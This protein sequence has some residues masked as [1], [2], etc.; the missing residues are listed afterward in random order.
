MKFGHAFQEALAAE[1]YP[2]HWVE[3]AIPYRQLKKLLGKVRE[4]LIKTG[5][6][7]DTIHQLLADHNAEYRL[8]TDAS[9]LL[10]P[11][12]VVRPSPGGTTPELAVEPGREPSPA[13]TAGPCLDL[14]ALSEPTSPALGGDSGCTSPHDCDDDHRAPDDDEWVKIPLNSDGRFFS[15]LQT[16][17]TELDSLQDEERQSM[18]DRIRVLGAEIAEVAKPRK[19][20]VKF[21]K[22]DL[23]RW[24]EIFE[25]YLA[26]QVFFSTNEAAGGLR[27]SDKAQKQLVWFQDEVNKRQLPQK[28][29]I[30]SSAAA[31]TQFLTLNATLLQNLQFQELNQTAIT[32]IIKKFDK[33]TSLGVKSTFPKAMYSAHF[34][35][36]AISKDICS[37]L[38]REVVNVVPQIVDYTC[39]ICLCLCWLPIRL[40]CSHLFCIRCM[41]KMQNQNKRYCPL[42]RADVVQNANET[43]IDEKLVRHLEQWFP[44]ETKEKQ[45]YNELERRRELLGDV[46]VGEE[47][48]KCL[49]M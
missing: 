1:S 37:Q 6:D 24:R 14:G 42:C 20:L 8:E 7:P 48:P 46:Y 49:V 38:A 21:S 11:K 22:S 26:A 23:Y 18:N 27:K 30:A 36:E 9:H 34:I 33:R 19:G 4:E 16:D 47:P 44:K 39:T 13:L 17:V 15:L 41:I 2:R 10:R 31:Y 35:S 12:L 43:H 3:K 5:Y 40:D 28:F 29:K 45:A 25:L 32:K